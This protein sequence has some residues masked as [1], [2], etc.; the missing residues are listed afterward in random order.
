MKN[1][2][3]RDFVLLWL[4]GGISLQLFE[5]A[6]AQYKMYAVK[7]G[8]VLLKKMMNEGNSLVEICDAV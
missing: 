6:F 4:R 1:K 3:L 2:L 7:I 8:P 5:N